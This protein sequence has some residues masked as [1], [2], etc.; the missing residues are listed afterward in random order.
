MNAL[1]LVPSDADTEELVLWST[2]EPCLMC[3]AA[4]DFTGIESIRWMAPD[5][6]EVEQPSGQAPADRGGVEWLVVANALFLHNVIAVAGEDHPIVNYNL[7]AE[8]EITALALDLFHQ[9]QLAESSQLGSALNGIW[10][11]VET[12]VAMRSQRIA[13]RVDR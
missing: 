13:R 1:A 5:P 10:E 4:V 12:A 11:R 9:Q 7:V 3:R 6:S 2:H 8:P